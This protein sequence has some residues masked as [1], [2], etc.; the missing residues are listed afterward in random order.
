MGMIRAT[1][2]TRKVQ[3][4]EEGVLHKWLESQGFNTAN[5]IKRTTQK[6]GTTLFEQFPAPRFKI[7]PD[8]SEFVDRKA[9]DRNK[10][11]WDKEGY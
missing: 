8:L 10:R 5:R 11:R 4:M 6:D 9:E 1:L 2:D 7:R 3:R